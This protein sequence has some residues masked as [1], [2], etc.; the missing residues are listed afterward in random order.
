LQGAKVRYEIF[1]KLPN[2]KTRRLSEMFG[3]IEGNK[4]N[5]RIEDYSVSQTSLE[6]IFN[7]FASQQASESVVRAAGP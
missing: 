7:F 4:T 1:S 3:V 6:Q 5:L 2:G